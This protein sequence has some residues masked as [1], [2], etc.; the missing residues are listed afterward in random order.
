[1]RLLGAHPLAVGLAFAVLALAGCA[2]SRMA[3]RAIPPVMI[4]SHAGDGVTVDGR[5]D[6]PVWA[7][8]RVYTLSRN[9]TEIAEGK[10]VSEPGEIRLAW[11]RDYFYLAAR[12]EDSDLTAEGE[13]DQ[14][15]HWQLGDVCELFLKPDEH[16]WYWELYV[17][18]RSC[19][20]SYWFPERGRLTLPSSLAYECGLRVAA[21]RK[22]T[23]DDWG[24]R[25]TGWTAEM[26]MP[27]EDLTA[28]GERFEPG[29]PWRILVGRYNYNRSLARP[30][31]SMVPP[32]P[33]TNFHLLGHYAVLEL[34]E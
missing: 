11:D 17:T 30:E 6:D 12:F 5:L 25:D 24:D 22:G 28:R 20:T 3:A 7:R 33:A 27:I 1:M 29:A 14:L 31:L 26:A 9:T 4:A 21:E 16:T 34:A 8:S 10:S 13:T 19:R 23:L 32:L 2:P 18:P 15:A